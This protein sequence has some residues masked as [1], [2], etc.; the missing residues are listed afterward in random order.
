MRLFRAP[1]PH[2]VKNPMHN[3]ISAQTPAVLYASLQFSSAAQSCPPLRDPMDCSTP[4]FSVHHQLLELVQ[5]HVLWGD[6]I[7]PSH[8]VIPFSSHLQSFPAFRQLGIVHYYRTHLLKKI[9][10]YKWIGVVQ[11]QV[12][13]R[14]SVLYLN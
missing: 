5:T 14:S 12:V 8:P 1:T 7:Q 6:A 13:Q 10:K 11:T 9:L 4:S 2:S 3:L